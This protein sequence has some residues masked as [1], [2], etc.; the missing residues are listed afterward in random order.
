MKRE[1]SIYPRHM[2]RY[3]QNLADRISK[4]KIFSS[5]C[6]RNTPLRMRSNVT[7]H[8]YS[9]LK[10]FNLDWFNHWFTL[11][12]FTS[13]VIH[14]FYQVRFITL[15]D[16]FLGSIQVLAERRGIRRS[17]ENLATHEI[18]TRDLPIWSPESYSWTTALSHFNHFW[19]KLH[20]DLVTIQLWMGIFPEFCENEKHFWKYL[21]KKRSTKVSM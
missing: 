11:K 5:C 10:G 7:Y 3:S 16:C 17:W 21:G 1:S 4:E 15:A 20:N 12:Y 13:I 8:S 19:F 6:R 14:V 9:E 2:S 18:W